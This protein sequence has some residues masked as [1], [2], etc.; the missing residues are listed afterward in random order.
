MPGLTRAEAGEMLT[1]VSEDVFRRTAFIGQAGLGVNAVPEL[2]KKMAAILTS[3]EE[4][5]SYTEAEKRLSEWQ[6]RRRY[7]GRGQLPQLEEEIEALQKTQQ[8][9]E[10]TVRRLEELEEQAGQARRQL[11]EEKSRLAQERERH[12]QAEREELDACRREAGNWTG[13]QGNGSGG[14]KPCARRWRSLPLPDAPRMSWR[15]R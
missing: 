10:E 2:E 1:G 13:R 9:A 7:R 5:T 14:R 4:D 3:G 6:R 15:P 8:E 11:E 12:L